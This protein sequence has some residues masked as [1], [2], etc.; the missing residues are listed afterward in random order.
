MEMPPIPAGSGHHPVSMVVLSANDMTKSQSFYTRLF[1]WQLHS[2][3]PELTA[4]V[5]PAGPSVS[6]RANAPQG[7]QGMVPFIGVSNVEES[8]ATIVNAGGT[9]EREPWNVPMAGTLARFTDPSGTVYGLSNG[10]PQVPVPPIPPPFGAN[11]TPPEGTVCAIEMYA[12]DAAITARFFGDTFAWGTLETMPQYLGFNP[13]AG[14]GGTFQSHT[15]AMPAVAYVYAANVAAKLDEIDA[16]GGK[17][18]ADAMAIAGVAT[19]GYFT[20]P[21]GTSMGLIGPA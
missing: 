15:P 17:R 4:A 2:I 18:M 7:F 12:R 14:I 11:P 1:S 6:L 16:A 20:D 19:F 9:I 10:M 5:T 8:L 21:S 3:S 13:G